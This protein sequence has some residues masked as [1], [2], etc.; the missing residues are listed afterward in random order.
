MS[1]SRFIGPDSARRVADEV[2]A[3]SI[4][5]L[6]ERIRTMRGRNRPRWSQYD[7]HAVHSLL[8]WAKEARRDHDGE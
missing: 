4:E 1:K 8:L 7:V 2:V 6:L 5:Y 3:E